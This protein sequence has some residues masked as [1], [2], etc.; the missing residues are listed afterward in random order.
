MVKK[1]NLS[2]D[3]KKQLKKNVLD[4]ISPGANNSSAK[5]LPVKAVVSSVS[6]PIKKSVAVKQP[7]VVVKNTTVPA[8]NI[9]TKPSI[10]PIKI[11]KTT[12]TTPVKKQKVKKV[13][14]ASK[15]N[16]TKRTSSTDSKVNLYAKNPS[17]IGSNKY[18]APDFEELLM[19]DM[20]K[21]PAVEP[22]RSRPAYR[23]IYKTEKIPAN[24]DSDVASSS[25]ASVPNDRP[26]G[27]RSPWHFTL[28]KAVIFVVLLIIFVL[29]LDVFGIYRLGWKDSFSYQTAK[30]LSL[31]AA[32]V[33]GHKITVASY[34]D[35]LKLLE[36]ALA[37]KRE[38]IVNIA[39]YGSNGEKIINRLVA[40]YLIEQKNAG[41][42]QSVSDKDVADQLASII[43]QMG[44]QRTAEQ[45][46]F[47]LY[48]L[49]LNQFRDKILKPLM[50]REALQSAIINDESLDVT[51]AAKDKAQNIL[52]LAQ[53]SSTDFTL[54]AKQ[55]TDDE[56]GV[57]TGG[58]LGWVAQKDVSSDWQKI[59]STLPVKTV[60]SQLVKDNQGY[61]VVKLEDRGLNPDTKVASF[62]LRHI[63]VKVDVDKYIKSLT[64]AAQIK[65]YITK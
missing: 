52:N 14:N 28:L 36:M 34:L 8:K 45:N 65:R 32:S 11:T 55:Y 40:I 15:K 38:G 41:Y 57:N 61:H 23:P 46:I 21:S 44:S 37:N 53:R 20:A 39:S 26:K 56:A 25:V 2:A 24:Q 12:K 22:V 47:D 17:P 1:V 50:E 59:F 16:T 7:V 18:S 49:N 51:K 63:L 9:A 3:K 27:V 10:L 43:Q 54:L 6:K 60:Y 5:E 30:Y 62:K 13:V 33:D 29:V 48:G 35:D 58:D 4:V 31:P 19:K 64:D 42:M